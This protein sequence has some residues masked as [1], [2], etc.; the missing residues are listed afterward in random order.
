MLNAY[1]YE[2][3]SD[4]SSKQFSQYLPYVY[5][6]N[7]LLYDDKY[8]LF[9]LIKKIIIHYHIIPNLFNN[10]PIIIIVVVN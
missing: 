5:V 10:I 4:S 9:L 6:K 1:Y 3:Y 8:L 7:A 2:I